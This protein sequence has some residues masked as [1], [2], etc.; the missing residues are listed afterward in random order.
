LDNKE[1]T[2]YQRQ[3]EHGETQKNVRISENMENQEDNRE[4]VCGTS[5]PL[6]GEIPKPP[7]HGIPCICQDRLSDLAL[8]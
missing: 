8:V 7:S 5:S 3:E 4:T 6:V 2:T 1:G